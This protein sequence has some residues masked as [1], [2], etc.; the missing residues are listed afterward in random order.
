MSEDHQDVSDWKGGRKAWEVMICRFPQ[1]LYE[2]MQAASDALG[3]YDASFVRLAVART[4]SDLIA[5]YR[6]E[7]REEARALVE[8]FV[9]AR[10]LSG[11]KKGVMASTPCAKADETSVRKRIREI[12]EDGFLLAKLSDLARRKKRLRE[13]RRVEGVGSVVDR[14]HLEALL[15]SAGHRYSRSVLCQEMERVFSRE[16]ESCC[17]MWFSTVSL[18]NRVIVEV[19]GNP[20]ERTELEKSHLCRIAMLRRGLT[21][22]RQ[23]RR[24]PRGFLRELQEYSVVLFSAWDDCTAKQKE[25]RLKKRIRKFWRALKG[26]RSARARKAK[27]LRKKQAKREI[28]LNPYALKKLLD[29]NEN[30][31]GIL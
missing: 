23:N 30:R 21:R 5:V 9:G 28:W 15:K 20:A 31:P 24:L 2:A 17:E 7:V 29:K 27:Q 3:M 6:D 22:L 19:Y 16:L 8:R 10:F 26:F 18:Q 12:Q 4:I 11:R 1:E 13:S 25:T 14:N